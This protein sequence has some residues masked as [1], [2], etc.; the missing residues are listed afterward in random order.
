[1][2]NLI[3][4]L[5]FAFICVIF[6]STLLS[7]VLV[8]NLRIELLIVFLTFIANTFTQNIFPNGFPQKNVERPGSKQSIA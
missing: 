3:L 8:G 6:Q 5:G 4:T 2:I 1:M 7:Y